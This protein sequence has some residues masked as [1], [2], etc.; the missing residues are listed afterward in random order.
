MGFVPFYLILQVDGNDVMKIIK[1]E[2]PTVLE[3]TFD[4]D[5]KMLLQIRVRDYDKII[6]RLQKVEGLKIE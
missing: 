3:Q 2:N 1:D 6:N 4:N 5:C